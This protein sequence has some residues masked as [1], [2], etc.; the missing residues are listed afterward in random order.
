MQ[1]MK[2]NG[3]GPTYPLFKGQQEGCQ[4]LKPEVSFRKWDTLDDIAP[5]LDRITRKSVGEVISTFLY[6]AGF[7]ALCTLILKKV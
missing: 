1:V 7:G 5:E 4:P 6:G 2:I 3:V